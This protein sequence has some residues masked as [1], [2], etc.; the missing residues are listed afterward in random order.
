MPLAYP[1]YG[2]PV[3]YEKYIPLGRV[4]HLLVVNMSWVYCLLKLEEPGLF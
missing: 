1:R 4:M 3:R 2:L